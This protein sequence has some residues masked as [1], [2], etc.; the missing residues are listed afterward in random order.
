MKPY[1][2]AFLILVGICCPSLAK[3]QSSSETTSNASE[4]EP[5]KPYH[6]VKRI[7]LPFLKKM[8]GQLGFDQE[9]G[10]LFFSDGKDLVV[11]NSGTGE[12][13]GL[14]PKIA[15]VSDVAFAPDIH[16]AF[17][18]DS[19]SRDLFAL[20]LSALTLVQKTNVG[21]ESSFVLYDSEAREVFTAGTESSSCKV[22]D[23]VTIKKVA[24]A[25]LRGYPLRAANDSNGHIYFQV[26]PND[27]RLPLLSVHGIY[28]APLKTDVEELDTRSLAVG[29][30]WDEAS[31]PHML[32]MGVGRSRQDLVMGCQ[33]SIALVDPQTR[34]VTATSTI[35]GVKPI[36]P[37]TVSSALGDAFFE[38]LDE[39]A[40]SHRVYLVIV[41][42]D[43]SGHLE[44]AVLAPQLPGR[45]AAFDEATQHIF[46]V[47]SDTKVT[48]T[49]LFFAPSGRE[50]TPL[51][52]P[53]PIPGTFRIL[54]Y[55]RN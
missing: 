52:V 29:D 48:D 23:A 54:V 18:V 33:N 46:I 53:Q 28:I 2:A 30:R 41:H 3:G 4:S 12:R 14:I 25:K 49:G 38:G 36:A 44:H 7:P 40:D 27:P 43:P 39:Q 15:N 31:C 51:R 37:L 45:P 16:R 21:T 34:K 50:M 19:Y 26:A 13:V 20:D 9:T 22:F 10:R 24:A 55:S 32:L 17:L 8:S 11:I 1:V 5:L 35:V 6:L 42:E 47:Q